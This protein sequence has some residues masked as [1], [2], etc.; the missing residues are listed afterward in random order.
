MSHGLQAEAC[1]HAWVGGGVETASSW[2]STR[3]LLTPQ[4]GAGAG[5]GGGEIYLKK[6]KPWAVGDH[7]V[8]CISV[9][10]VCVLDVLHVIEYVCVSCSVFSH[11]LSFMVSPS[12]VVSLPP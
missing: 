3:P 10:M 7:L 2:C 9:C 5:G 11:T 4:A 8:Q 6:I 12:H 1:K